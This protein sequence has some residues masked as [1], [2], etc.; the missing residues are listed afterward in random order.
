[1]LVKATELEVRYQNVAPPFNWKQIFGNSAPVEI[2]IGFGKCGFL[3]G[4]ARACPAVNFLGIEMSRKYYRKG[5]KKIQRTDLKNVKLLW[6]EAFHLFKR[7]I[8]HRSVAHIYVNFPDPW[9][10]K[11]HAKRRLLTGEFLDVAADT[12]LPGGCLEIATD[13]ETYMADTLKTLQGHE[14]YRCVY[15]LTN[16]ELDNQ[17]QFCSDY[18]TGFLEEGKTLYYAK[19]R[20]IC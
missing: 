20:K 12:L 18:E 16:A 17:R 5:I 11:R 14:R 8:A 3:I 6:G 7:Y 4:V 9:P 19:Y 2:E 1:M 13:V 15:S 10:K